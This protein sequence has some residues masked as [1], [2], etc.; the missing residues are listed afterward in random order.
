MSPFAVANK[1]YF[2]NDQIAFESQLVQA[3]ILRRAPIR[4][5]IRFEYTGSGADRRCLASA[6]LR[7][8]PDEEVRYESPPIKDIK[9]KNSPLWTADPDQQL[10]YY[11]GRALCR[12]HF[13]DVLLGILDQEEVAEDG[14]SN[15]EGKVRGGERRR[16]ARSCSCGVGEYAGGGSEVSGGWWFGNRIG[17]GSGW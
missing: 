2:V 16:E 12:R 9:V 15:V 3:V 1:S 10:S 7:D 17:H 14:L 4:G 11:A 6:R 5:R 13:P 8:D